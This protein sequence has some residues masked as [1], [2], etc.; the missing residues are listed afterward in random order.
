MREKKFRAWDKEKKF[1]LNPEH[2]YITGEGR[3][4]TC[5]DTK[6]MYSTTYRYMGTA[7]Y[8]I[9]QSTGKLDKNGDETFGGMT[10]R[11]EWHD[12]EYQE[13]EEYTGIVYFEDGAFWLQMTLNSYD[14]KN[15]EIIPGEDK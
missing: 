2:F 1:W 10:V 15:L 3:G 14:S 13:G 6:G 12:P 4:F 7:R 8:C 9:T 11:Y 5:E